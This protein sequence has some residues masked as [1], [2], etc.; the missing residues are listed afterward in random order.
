MIKTAAVQQ[1][2]E[3]NQFP[4]VHGWVLDPQDGLLGDLQVDSEAMPEDVKK[5]YCLSKESTDSKSEKQ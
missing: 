5:I 3:R 4:I 1:S 2:Y